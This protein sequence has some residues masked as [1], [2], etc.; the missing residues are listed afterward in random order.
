VSAGEVRR[1]APAVNPGPLD[2][3]TISPASATIGAGAGQPYTAQGFDV[4]GNGLGDVTDS[5]TFSITPDGSC[6]NTVNPR[7]CSATIPGPHTVTGTDSGKTATAS[8]SVKGI[9]ITSPNGGEIWPIGSSRALQWASGGFTGNLKIEVS[10]DGGTAWALV[11]GKTAN[12]GTFSWTVT[13]PATTQA[14]VRVTSLTDPTVAD[15]SDANFTIGGGSL[16]VT[17]PNGGE[18][19]PIGSL[20]AIQW[21][22]SG[23]T[24][25]VKIEIS[26]DG[27]VTWAS[28]SGGTASDGAFNWKVRGPATTQARIRITSVTDPTVA[29]VSNV[30]FSI[31]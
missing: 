30:N 29:D 27:G 28:L 1:L 5:T 13:G 23:L 9:A 19:W 6:N 8:L 4:H 12:S 26:R 16:A 2:H 21:T 14:R 3:I 7:T 31:Q 20:Q 10:R 22:S 18:T 15:A 17:T 25:K 11:K 24:G